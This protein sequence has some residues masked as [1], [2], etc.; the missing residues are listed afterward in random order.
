[1]NKSRFLEGTD[2]YND[3]TYVVSDEGPPVKIRNG[4]KEQSTGQP[5]RHGGHTLKRE[6]QTEADTQYLN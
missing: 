5:P 4:K 6:K 2:D 3:G 1:M